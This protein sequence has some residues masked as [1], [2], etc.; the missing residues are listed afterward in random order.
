M[1]ATTIHTLRKVI[2]HCMV[3]GNITG[4]YV[5]TRILARYVSRQLTIEPHASAHDRYHRMMD[6]LI[7]NGNPRPARLAANILHRIQ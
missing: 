4:A 6:I 3:S 7:Q 5:Y 2:S 1:S